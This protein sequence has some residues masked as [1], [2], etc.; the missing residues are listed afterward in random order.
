MLWD[1][2]KGSMP[3]CRCR[4][5]ACKFQGDPLKRMCNAV[6]SWFCSKRTK[7]ADAGVEMLKFQDPISP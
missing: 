6:R 4:D 2:T 1:C 5:N 3:K 7:G